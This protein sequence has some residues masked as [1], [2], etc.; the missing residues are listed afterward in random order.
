MTMLARGKF[1]QGFFRYLGAIGRIGGGVSH[2]QHA[3]VSRNER[4]GPDWGDA[5][6]LEECAEESDLAAVIGHRSV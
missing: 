4:F 6:S 3:A 1:T 2:S 5:K